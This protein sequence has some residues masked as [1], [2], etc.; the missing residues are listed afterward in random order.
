MFWIGVVCKIDWYFVVRCHL[1]EAYGWAVW[2]NQHI[3]KC[4]ISQPSSSFPD[5]VGCFPLTMCVLLGCGN[6]SKI[7]YLQ[8]DGAHKTWWD[9]GSRHSAYSYVKIQ[10]QNL[11]LW[12]VT[13]AVNHRNW[14]SEPT[15]LCRSRCLPEL[16]PFD[17]I[18]PL[19]LASFPVHVLVQTFSFDFIVTRTEVQWKAFV[20]C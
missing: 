6:Y 8:G 16:V 4:H 14:S 15:R 17:C 20:A 11:W 7:Y 12:K 18:W 13:H 5:S 1:C 10:E 2:I 19:L 9:G 3:P